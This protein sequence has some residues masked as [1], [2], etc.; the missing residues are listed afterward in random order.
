MTASPAVRAATFNAVVSMLNRRPTGKELAAEY[1]ARLE[2]ARTATPKPQAHRDSLQRKLAAAERK[3]QAKVTPVVKPIVIAP[4]NVLQDVKLEYKRTMDT[5]SSVL[6]LPASGETAFGSWTSG[7]QIKAIK[8]EL[9]DR[10][11]VG[12]TRHANAC[13]GKSGN[14]GY[15]SATA[16]AAGREL[17]LL[18]QPVVAAH[19]QGL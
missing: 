16:Q 5:L 13:A 19:S 3:A 7:K 18:G 2:A 6:A 15:R 8:R 9:A 10:P 12:G 14:Y 17:Y 11:N 4:V 1:T